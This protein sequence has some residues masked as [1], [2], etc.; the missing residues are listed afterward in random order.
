MAFKVGFLSFLLPT[1]ITRNKFERDELAAMGQIVGC[2]RE[3][4]G[5]KE[6]GRLF[7]Y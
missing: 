1:K 6:N 3:L 5:N 7:K 2:K 4:S